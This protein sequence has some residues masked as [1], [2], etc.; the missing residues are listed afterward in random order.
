VPVGLE[1]KLPPFEELD[2]DTVGL[3][4]K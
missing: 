4:L 3:F 1:V 2:Y